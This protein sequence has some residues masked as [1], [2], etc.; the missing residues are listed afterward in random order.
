M[1]FGKYESGTS[2]IL[3]AL[4]DNGFEFAGWTGA[5]TGDEADQI[6]SVDGD[7]IVTATFTRTKYQ[8]S[9]IIS[10]AESG[11]VSGVGE[12][13]FESPIALEAI[14]AEG[15]R[16]VRWD[17]ELLEGEYDNPL[18][19]N[20]SGVLEVKAM[21]EE[22]Q[23]SVTTIQSP[24]EGGFVSGGGILIMVNSFSSSHSC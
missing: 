19:I 17:G 23:Y 3:S 9:A 11:A 24:S 20:V 2:A 5:I 15:Y 12:Y 7:V 21:F 22:A 4:P 8:V 14:P 13:E 1:G 16:F 10:P 6:L 18:S